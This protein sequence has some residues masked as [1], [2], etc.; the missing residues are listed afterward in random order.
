VR[1]LKGSQPKEDRRKPGK[2]LGV[3]LP[4]KPG[5]CLVKGLRERRV[6]L[7]REPTRMLEGPI[8][9]LLRVSAENDGLEDIHK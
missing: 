2:N 8:D 9:H 7:E 4:G 5:E 1:E 6:V 3:E